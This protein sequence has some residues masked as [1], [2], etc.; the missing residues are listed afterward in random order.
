[1]PEEMFFSCVCGIPGGLRD[2]ESSRGITDA[3]INSMTV[4][5]S[6]T[7]RP[8][9][10]RLRIFLCFFCLSLTLEEGRLRFD[11]DIFLRWWSGLRWVPHHES[12]LVT[13]R[14]EV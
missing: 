3:I 6:F 14:F 1:M 13:Q 5:F 7:F 2:R 11:T 9:K 8:Q 4:K 10:Y 12:W